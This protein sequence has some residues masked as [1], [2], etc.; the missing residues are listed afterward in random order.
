MDGGGLRA[1]AR[2][3]GG[4]GRGGGHASGR[5][6]ARAAQPVATG[7][8]AHAGERGVHT[9]APSSINAWFKSPGAG[10]SA[11]IFDLANG[12][13]KNWGRFAPYRNL[14]YAAAAA[15]NDGPVALGSVGAG[16]GA[17]TVN[18][19]GGI[20]SASA[21]TSFGARVGALMVVNALGLSGR[22]EFSAMPDSNWT[23]SQ[24]NSQ[25]KSMCLQS[26]P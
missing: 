1:G 14:G 24:P 17:T 22:A 5:P 2:G 23:S 3:E 20:G 19:K 12:G 11:I 8:R 10:P 13:N 21:V 6:A 9:V 7:H 25:A 15:A 26:K 4:G 18:L 16:L